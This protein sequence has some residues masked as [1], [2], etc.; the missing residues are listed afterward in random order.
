MPPDFFTRFAVI[1]AFLGVGLFILLISTAVV[2]FPFPWN[3]VDDSFS[4]LGSI[5]T[6]N[7]AAG[8]FAAS[9]SLG[10][11]SWM[12]VVLVYVRALL[13]NWKG[14]KQV[15]GLLG[16]MF[17]LAGRAI[18][19]VVCMFPTQPW[20][21]VHDYIAAAWLGCEIVGL[22]FIA[23]EMCRGRKDMAWGFI[24]FVLIFVGVAFWLPYVLGIW[25]G[26]AIP[27]IASMVLV[28]SY[29]MALWARAWQGKVAIGVARTK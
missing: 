8:F 16:F 6:G 26:I 12:P 29:S 20:H 7:Y 27:E 17:Q 4:D 13:A 28:Y 15:C 14:C 22:V 21:K 23:I 5:L 10:A 3:A 24:P 18:A 19:V 25:G 11:V 9:L 2:L 1:M